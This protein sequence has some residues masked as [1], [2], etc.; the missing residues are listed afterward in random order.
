VLAEPPTIF[1]PP[2]ILRNVICP[3]AMSL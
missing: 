3:L 2:P 1:R